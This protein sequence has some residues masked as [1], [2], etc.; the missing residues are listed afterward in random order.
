MDRR[1]FLKGMLFGLPT[2]RAGSLVSHTGHPNK[3]ALSSVNRDKLS[4]FEGCFFLAIDSKGHVRLPDSFRTVMS[5]RGGDGLKVTYLDGS[6]RA[7]TFEEWREMDARIRSAANA[8]ESMRQFRRILIGSAWEC[9]CDI[10]GRIQIPPSFRQH[11]ELEREIVLVGLVDHFEIWSC[12]NW[13][14]EIMRM[15]DDFTNAGVSKTTS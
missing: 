3:S 1:T 13:N 14:K 6:L 15:K 2:L 7:Y 5:A 12:K 11:A 8:S 9:L 10:Q 4:G